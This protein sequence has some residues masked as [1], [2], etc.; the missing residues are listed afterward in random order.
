[1][2]LYVERQ[3][4]ISLYGYISRGSGTYSIWGERQKYLARQL[5]KLGLITITKSRK[6]YGEQLK[7][8]W[9][10][11]ALPKAKLMQYFTHCNGL[12]WLGN[13]PGR[14]NSISILDRHGINHTNHFG[15]L[16]FASEDDQ[17]MA[18]M[19]YGE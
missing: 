19:H 6:W 1:M 15:L 12:V 9:E 16:T 5:E 13:L 17:N 18:L 7:M 10:V 4:M 14:Q 3:K 2:C 8:V 11:K